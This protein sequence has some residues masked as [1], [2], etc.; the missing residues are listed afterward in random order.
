MTENEAPLIT[1]LRE[2]GFRP[3][4]TAP[5]EW[6]ATQA[7]RPRVFGGWMTICETDEGLLQRN[8]KTGE[9]RILKQWVEIYRT[10]ENQ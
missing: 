1:L 8:I 7:L 2:K 4:N 9:T 10:P 3:V 5:I 6:T